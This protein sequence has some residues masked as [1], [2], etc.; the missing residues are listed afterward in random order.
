MSEVQLGPTGSMSLRVSASMILLVFISLC[1]RVWARSKVRKG[2]L[3][4]DMLIF[5]AAA[6]FY[7]N[8]GT[9]LHGNG[10]SG[11]SDFTLMTEHQMNRFL[12]YLFVE[13]ILFLLGITATKFS[14]L[15]FYRHIFAV[16]SFIRINW[17]LMGVCACWCI[18]AF[19]VIVFECNP[20]RA[21]WN[22]NTLRDKNICIPEGTMIAGFGIAEI[23]I[24]IMILAH[25]AVMVRNLQMP[26]LKRASLMG[27]FLLG[28]L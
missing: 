21:M 20:V 3:P 13:E 19:F 5:L 10:S 18:I 17:I 28:G 4:E 22:Y 8:Q 14:I 23:P 26:V 24:D 25:P 15:T 9:F 6:M 16:P 27:V 7:A 12:K 2:I 1:L 11:G